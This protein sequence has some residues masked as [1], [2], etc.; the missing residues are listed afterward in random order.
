MAW[1]E[2]ERIKAEVAARHDSGMQLN[3]TGGAAGTADLKTNSQGKRGAIEAL[4]KY[5]G[6]GLDKAG[7][8]ADDDTDAAEREFKGWA[9]GAGLK[10]A[11]EEWALQVK[12]LKMR[13]AQDRV[14]L[15]KTRR[16]F[17]YVDHGVES[18][19]AQIAPPP[20]PNPRRNA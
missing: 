11:H 7:V 16:D 3:G 10:D 1:D 5:I 4:V 6:P 18:S 19:L 9:T 14:A 20:A 8:H 12:S 15:S 17:Q 13:L 2:W